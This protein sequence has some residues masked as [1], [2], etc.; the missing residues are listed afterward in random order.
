MY[1][2]CLLFLLGDF[3][4]ASQQPL[5]PQKQLSLTMLSPGFYVPVSYPFQK[6]MNN[7]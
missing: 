4:T 1:P 7:L 2:Q 5:F 6:K 3:Y